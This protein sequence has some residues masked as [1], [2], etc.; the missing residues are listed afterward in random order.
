MPFENIDVAASGTVNTRNL[1]QATRKT[2]IDAGC[3]R[4]KMPELCG[5]QVSA[6]NGT[7]NGV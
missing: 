5:L 2:D 6:A 7:H 4:N 3:S 1:R